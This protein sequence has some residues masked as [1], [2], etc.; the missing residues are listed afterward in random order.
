MGAFCWYCLGPLAHHHNQDTKVSCKIEFHRPE[1]SLQR[2]TEAALALSGHFMLL[3]P[4]I[5]HPFV[6]VYRLQRSRLVQLQQHTYLRRTISHCRNFWFTF[7][8]VLLFTSKLIWLKQDK[9]LVITFTLK[10]M[11][12][13]FFCLVNK[14]QSQTNT[15]LTLLTSNVTWS[16]THSPE[17]SKWIHPVL[18]E[19]SNKHRV[20]TFDTNYSVHLF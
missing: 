15:K 10:A 19:V 17:Q 13:T 5:C 6:H 20:L 11:C 9:S 7:G 4:L 12:S 18:K 8:P 2:G 16:S 1:Q 14:S 3:F